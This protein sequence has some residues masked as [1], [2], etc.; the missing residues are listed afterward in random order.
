MEEFFQKP[1]GRACFFREA[2]RETNQDW[3]FFTPAQASAGPHIN[4]CSGTA[5][6]REFISQG[7]DD[8]G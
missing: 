5:A 1:F 4:V 7:G 2:A 3:S 8:I 6:M